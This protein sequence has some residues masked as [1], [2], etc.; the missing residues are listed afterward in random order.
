MAAAT[1]FVTSFMVESLFQLLTYDLGHGPLFCTGE[2]P[3]RALHLWRW[4]YA[5]DLWIRD[6]QETVGLDNGLSQVWGDRC[7]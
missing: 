6:M 5:D 2:Q 3:A 1:C 7:G 4:M